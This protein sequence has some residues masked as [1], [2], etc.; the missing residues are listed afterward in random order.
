MQNICMPLINYLS[1]YSSWNTQIKSW[2]QDCGWV[3]H[4]G[5]NTTFVSIVIGK[6]KYANKKDYPF[7]YSAIG[8][9]GQQGQPNRCDNSDDT[10]TLYGFKIYEWNNKNRKIIFDT[11]NSECMKI[12]KN[13]FGNNLFTTRKYFLT[14]D[15]AKKISKSYI[16]PEIIEKAGSSRKLSA[17]TYPWGG[18]WTW[19]YFSNWATCQNNANID[20]YFSQLGY[21]SDVWKYPLYAYPVGIVHYDDHGHYGENFLGVD[22]AYS[23]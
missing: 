15:E 11:T 8:E 21:P 5:R 16:D 2:S 9:H 10:N 1:E 20:R 18:G 19:G 17:R 3:S 14:L 7:A 6:F 13:N 12:Y 23:G 4:E 22:F